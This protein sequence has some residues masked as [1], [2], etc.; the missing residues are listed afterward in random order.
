MVCKYSGDVSANP[1][2]AIRLFV[3]SNS[4]TGYD[5]KLSFANVVLL[6]TVYPSLLVVVNYGCHGVM[7]S[8]TGKIIV[9]A[10]YSDVM[11][12]SKDL[13]MVELNGNEENNL[14]FNSKGVKIEQ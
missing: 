9:P 8:R 7:D 1:W 11:L 2:D 4:I 13:I 10:V 3:D 12:I 6:I 14:V 5:Y